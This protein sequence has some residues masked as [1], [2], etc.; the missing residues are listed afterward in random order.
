MNIFHRRRHLSA[1]VA[2]QTDAGTG[3]RGGNATLGLVESASPERATPRAGRRHSAAR[4][5][6]R[7]IL[8]VVVAN[9]ILFSWIAWLLSRRPAPWK[10]PAGWWAWLSHDDGTALVDAERT[11]ATIL[12]VVAVA[13]AAVIAYRWQLT[14]E[15]SQKTA[16][17]QL[18]L[19][20]QKYELDRRRHQLEKNRRHDDREREL[21]ARFSAIAEE[22]GSTKYAVRQAGAYALA[23]LAD[24][25]HRFGNDRERQV[26]VDLLCAQ[27]RSPRIPEGTEGSEADTEVRQSMIGLMRS[28]RPLEAAAGLDWRSC[29]IDLSGADLSGLSLAEID[30]TSADLTNSDLTNT[31]LIKANLSRAS[32]LLATITNTDFSGAD[33]TRASLVGAKVAEG[34]DPNDFS[35]QMLNFRRA[36]LHGT[37]LNTAKL[38]RAD[39]SGSDLTYA[40]FQ[41]A[42]LKGALF[43]G[44]TAVRAQFV[45]ANLSDT[46]FRDADLRGANLNRADVTGAKFTDIRWDAET[47]WPRGTVPDGLQ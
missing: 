39:F 15:S 41:S 12:A 28:R 33:L 31:K 1:E 14:A 4:L 47:V 42:K 17:E 19:D 8:A 29:S 34:R 30:L 27:L 45:K 22:L 23:S 46:D 13:V 3:N 18:Q 25:W 38:F 40:T 5:V 24:D 11:T 32:L 43:G 21:R 44:V 35:W 16:T 6:L 26:C 36:C 37:L 10:D 2:R 7:G 9:A 20:S